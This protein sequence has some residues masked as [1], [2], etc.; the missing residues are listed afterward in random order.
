ME[1]R[2]ITFRK[3]KSICDE[4]YDDYSD[5]ITTYY[6]YKLIDNYKDTRCTAKNCP[7]WRK[8]KVIK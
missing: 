8:L 4:K 7:V 1:T 2:V 5:N 6:C 3:L